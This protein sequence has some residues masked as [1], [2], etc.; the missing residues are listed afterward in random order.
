METSP[1]HSSDSWVQFSQE[2]D[3]TVVVAKFP[4]IDKD[5]FCLLFVTLP[6]SA[7]DGDAQPD[8]LLGRGYS[9]AS[10][11]IK[12]LCAAIQDSCTVDAIK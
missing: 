9:P 2:K 3:K 7:S 8:D 1:G 11:S 10:F 12:T 6:N 4:H 5:Y